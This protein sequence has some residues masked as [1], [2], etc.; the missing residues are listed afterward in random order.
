MSMSSLLQD[1]PGNDH[2]SPLK[3]ANY[4]SLKQF[5]LFNKDGDVFS[6][7]QICRVSWKQP[8]NFST[9]VSLIEHVQRLAIAPVHRAPAAAPHEE[10][11]NLRRNGGSGN[12]W[13]GLLARASL[14]DR[15]VG[16]PWKS[17]K[18]TF[19]GRKV[20]GFTV[21]YPWQFP[22]EISSVNRIQ[23]W[24]AFKHFGHHLHRSLFSFD[25]FWGGIPVLN[26]VFPVVP[27]WQHSTLK[28][29]L[30]AKSILI[31]HSHVSLFILHYWQQKTYLWNLSN[32]FP[33]QTKHGISQLHQRFTTHPN[34]P[35]KTRPPSA[36]NP[37][38]FT[39][40]TSAPASNNNCIACMLPG[41]FAQVVK[42]ETQPEGHLNNQVLVDHGWMI[43]KWS[44]QT[45]SW[46]LFTS[47]F[48]V[49][50]QHNV[51][52]LCE[53]GKVQ[54]QIPIGQSM[55]TLRIEAG[56]WFGFVYF[57]DSFKKVTLQQL[58]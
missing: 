54:M 22:Q 26:Y 48:C 49:Q 23:V 45:Y 17:A 57:R 28:G 19:K 7:L 14:V 18:K 16:L 31:A 8:P 21:A 1:L 32:H 58:T 53:G 41:A 12:V 34:P 11:P 29:H 36:T 33:S 20:C 43:M 6:I 9:K 47:S 51:K 3:V 52:R 2:I 30:I 15:A 50:T 35:P 44:L 5:F 10:E 40:S 46:W 27:L 24:H 38:S 42:H 37:P 25:H 39:K 56:N 13:Q 4:Q 55:A